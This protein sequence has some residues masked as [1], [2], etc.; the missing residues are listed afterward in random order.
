[1]SLEEEEMAEWRVLLA[2]LAGVRGG[3][4][5]GGKSHGLSRAEKV[6]ADVLQGPKR[7]CRGS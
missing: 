1:M 5:G 4:E 7:W 3:A 2:S 6:R